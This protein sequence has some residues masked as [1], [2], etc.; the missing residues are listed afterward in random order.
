MR[1]SSVP[2][3][4]ANE[5]DETIRI[6]CKTWIQ[7]IEFQTYLID[8]KLSNF[9]IYIYYD[10]NMCL[11]LFHSSQLFHRFAPIFLFC[12]HDGRQ[13]ERDK[14]IV[15]VKRNRKRFMLQIRFWW[16]N[17]FSFV[18]NEHFIILLISSERSE[19]V[20]A[21]NCDSEEIN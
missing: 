21:L 4:R 15:Y 11:S 17:E 16:C 18:C 3:D 13:S 10:R 7:L 5:R 14:E 1:S 9:V 2:E 12:S 8:D 6:N 20:V 19:D